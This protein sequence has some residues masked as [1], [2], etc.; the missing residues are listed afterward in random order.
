M[1]PVRV[2][3]EGF[4]SYREPAV[5]DFSGRNLWLLWGR[6][7]VG[8]STVFDA[9]TFAL[10]GEGRFGGRN[11]RE[12]L[13]H[14][15]SQMSVAF[16][17]DLGAER[18]RVKRTAGSQ[19][20]FQVFTLD[21]E[22]E[23]RATPVP[24]THTAAG[25]K[26][27]VEDNFPLDSFT[28]SAAAL[29]KQGGAEVLLA[30]DATDRR[31]FM[32]KVVNLR[33]YINLQMEVS[34][35]AVRLKN[36][37]ATL[38]AMSA[39]VE[40]KATGLVRAVR[41][42]FALPE[43]QYPDAPLW[44]TVTR[45]RDRLAR[46]TEELEVEITGL[47]AARDGL[48]GL[49][50][51][52]SLLSQQERAI[53][54]RAKLIQQSVAFDDTLGRAE[55]I[56]ERAERFALLTAVADAA[57]RFV[58]ARNEFLEADQDAAR[59]RA[60]AERAQ[61]EEERLTQERPGAE[62]AV[63]AARVA[64][65]A[66]HYELARAEARCTEIQ[67]RLRLLESNKDRPECAACGQPLSPGHVAEERQRLRESESTAAA[68]C[69]AAAAAFGTRETELVT[70]ER[71]LNDIDA[72][73][74][75]AGERRSNA[76]AAQTVAEARRERAGADAQAACGAL[77]EI[78]GAAKAAPWAATLIAAATTES[79][80][81]DKTAPSLIS[82]LRSGEPPS[83][84]ADPGSDIALLRAELAALAG[85]DA[86]KETLDAA[87][88]EAEKLAARIAALEADIRSADALLDP[89]GDGN[90]RL[91]AERARLK[92]LRDEIRE[93]LKTEEARIREGDGAAAALRGFT[94][95]AG[96]VVAAAKAALERVRSEE[97]SARERREAAREYGGTLA[98]LQTDM[99]ALEATLRET[100]RAFLLHD[101]LARKLDE[102]NL[103]AVL[104]DRAEAA[105]VANADVILQRLSGGSLRLERNAN[106]DEA[107]DLCVRDFEK[108]DRAMRPAALSGSQKFR[109]AVALALGIGQYAA[110][111]SA[112][113]VESVI[114]DEGFGSLDREGRERMIEELSR[115]STLLKRV[116]VVSHQEEFE[117]A[118]PNQWN[119]VLEGNTARA[120]LRG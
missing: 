6:N 96:R 44:T 20:T 85:A 38:R 103:Q 108:G 36:E 69:T 42:E 110:A 102:G 43:T 55:V 79:E 16:D 87:R 21:P 84:G 56:E 61:Q 49:V 50:A 51:P 46:T 112:G 66:A 88:T 39:D 104:R 73:I 95:L 37:V 40:K 117:N 91:E 13:N 57:S 47:E 35:K 83:A 72:G 105:I 48:V 17:F 107:L 8:K 98:S 29:L 1:V 67:N 22:R 25:F 118:F 80:A 15:C 27:W 115:L 119:I 33:P 78:Q 45:V 4:L 34:A 68:A 76:R 5:L 28:F 89:G 62:K 70:A 58:A 14:H 82:L 18:F 12:Y 120:V 3:L 31:K 9:I 30:A 53:I 100:L 23:D 93:S 2:H 99:E 74:R 26:S 41:A 90:A 111:G 7:G 101:T 116:V 10:F 52:G 63:E 32:A 65:D 77:A 60:E 11:V 54:E 71:N 106:S 19:S 81:P 64:R 92:A 97:A 94:A 86:E 114:V 75:S 59:A 113:G 24:G 109:L